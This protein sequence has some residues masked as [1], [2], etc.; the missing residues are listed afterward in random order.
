[1]QNREKINQD[2]IAE[3]NEY[4]DEA[5]IWWRVRYSK[6]Y[7]KCEDWEQANKGFKETLRRFRDYD[8]VLEASMLATRQSYLANFLENQEE[9]RKLA[10]IALEFIE[11]AKPGE[12]TGPI[13]IALDELTNTTFI[14]DWDKYI[15]NVDKLMRPYFFRSGL[16]AD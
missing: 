13:K 12:P 15:A 14:D 4:I 11:E 8:Q 7:E 10:S 6:L 5:S 16:I 3:L 9:S 1:L 2:K